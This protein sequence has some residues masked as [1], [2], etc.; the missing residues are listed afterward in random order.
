MFKMVCSF[1]IRDHSICRNINHPLCIECF[2]AV[3]TDCVPVGRVRPGED[4]YKIQT[5]NFYSLANSQY[6]DLDSTYN[7]ETWDSD[8]DTQANMIQHPCAQLQKLFSNGSF[9]FTPDFDLT[10]TVQAR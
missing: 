3:V 8:D 10:R 1:L 5:V 7:K 4:V 2:L 6:D 9:Y